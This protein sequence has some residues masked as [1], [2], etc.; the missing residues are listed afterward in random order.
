MIKEEKLFFFF[1]FLSNSTILIQR[2]KLIRL[3]IGLGLNL[4]L[5]LSH[6]IVNNVLS[7]KYKVKVFVLLF[8]VIMTGK[9]AINTL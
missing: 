2:P 3:V 7:F 5:A 4:G 8:P 1:S 9:C 6:Y